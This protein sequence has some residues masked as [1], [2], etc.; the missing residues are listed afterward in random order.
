LRSLFFLRFSALGDVASALRVVDA[1]AAAEPGRPITFVTHARYTPLASF[2]RHKV[3]VLGYRS[4]ALSGFGGL[5][6]TLRTDAGA[7]VDLHNSSRTTAARLL[8]PKIPW[9]TF[10]KRR[11][12]RQALCAGKLAFAPTFRPQQAMAQL[13]GVT[14]RD[15]PW[16]VHP[17]P[18]NNG[19]VMVPGAAWAEKRWPV[20]RFAELARACTEAGQAVRVLLS[21]GDQLELEGI[22]WGAAELTLDASIEQCVAHLAGADAVLANDTG[23]AHVAEGL[24]RPLVVLIGPTDQRMGAAPQGAARH[25]L[26]LRLNLDCQPCSQKG[27]RRCRVGGRPCLTELSMSQVQDALAAVVA[28]H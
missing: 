8:L 12:D 23:F 17:A 10:D 19:L 3:Q 2:L 5:L 18:I 11:R 4:D 27:D 1:A 13:A 20:E 16:L 9:R 21:S 22:N 14:L 24:G 7:V 25:S 28:A 26:G 15:G 6:R